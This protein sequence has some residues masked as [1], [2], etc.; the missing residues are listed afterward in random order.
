MGAGTPSTGDE[1]DT[2]DRGAPRPAGGRQR[3]DHRGG[4]CARCPP[5]DGPAWS[6][7]LKVPWGR[8]VGWA[9]HRGSWPL[10]LGRYAEVGGRWV[11][12]LA[13]GLSR[14][15]D[16]VHGQSELLNLTNGILDTLLPLAN[17]R[18][19]LAVWTAQSAMLS[20]GTRWTTR[21]A[22]RGSAGRT[23]GRLRLDGQED[24]R[25]VGG[26]GWHAD[27]GAGWRGRR[28]R[29]GARTGELRL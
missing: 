11:V 12:R 10:E 9:P 6:R 18:A 5:Y 21:A 24:G 2:P 20:A 19:L 1:E 3:D 14:L 13:N 17:Q 29:E 27:G 22:I 7:A 8:V 16:S 23:R 15:S 4:G 25:A 26:A 28:R